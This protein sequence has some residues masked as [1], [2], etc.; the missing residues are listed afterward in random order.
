GGD[1]SSKRLTAAQRRSKTG[2]AKA[3]RPEPKPFQLDDGH[4]A[5]AMGATAAAGPNESAPAAAE[6]APD[7]AQAGYEEPL[8]FQQLRERERRH[9]AVQLKSWAPKDAF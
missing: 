3:P 9:P 4:A 1:S 6:S 5:K 7:V 8:P 2:L